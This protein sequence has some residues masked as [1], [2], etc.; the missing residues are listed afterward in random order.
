MAQAMQ[1][2]YFALLMVSISFVLFLLVRFQKHISIY[3]TLMTLAVV[4]VNLG[5]L[6]I[7]GAKTEEG[8]L[9]GNQ[10]YCL[11]Y[12]FLLLF[13]IQSIA[14]L[15]K[16]RI[17][18]AL[19]ALCIVMSLVIFLGASSAGYS[20]LYYRSVEMVI[21][22]GYTFLQ[23][24][25][26]PLHMLSPIY[27]VITLGSG[28]VIVVNALRKKKHVSHVV[29]VGSMCL[30][31]LAA[32]TFVG[33]RAVGL[34]VELL[35]LAYTICAAGILLM[36]DRVA[37]Y[38]VEGISR[39]S[40]EE[41]R[42]YGFVICDDKLRLSGADEQAKLWFPELN[43]LK[44]DY[45]IQEFSTDFLH[46]LRKWVFDADP[47]DVV[48]FERGGRVL[49]ATHSSPKVN[50]RTLHCIRLRDDTAQQQYL[51]LVERYNEKLAEQ[52][53]EKTARLVE[54]QN[55]IIVSMASIVEN[56]DN[57]T[58]G[59]IR[60]TSDVV[61]VFVEHLLDSSAAPGLTRGTAERIITAA[62]LHDF[63]KIA[64]PDSILNKP[65]KFVPEEYEVMKQHAQKGA[66]IVAQIL[67]N[68]DDLQFKDI[69]VNVAHYHH[70]KWDGSGY[71]CGL[72][73]EEIPLEARIMA[74]ADVFDALVSKRVYKEM[75]SFDKAFRI[76]EESSGSHFDPQL[77][78]AFLECREQI[79][80]LYS[81]NLD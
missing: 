53:E 2:L 69:A 76:I 77:C 46:Q 66:G 55:D 21:R 79:E 58:G 19:R 7:A 39:D 72:A 56:R 33:E 71:P 57:N 44:I 13:T 37:T 25:Y 40:L 35:P 70:E 48:F 5:Y 62:P 45:R 42:E 63:G 36:L 50:R 54:V 28:L 3:Y 9:L 68:S 29:S 41:S 8:A 22:D 15:C 11:A 73:G 60:R 18:V 75:Y 43:K 74:L 24:E 10:V 26:G 67:Q 31:L 81:G 16:T 12:P 65:G 51:K 32:L 49:E 59:H 78:G 80:A 4:I 20:D 17:P 27:I 23:R 52:V 47:Q 34:Q 1:P 38:D 14:D 30:L 6:Q 64:I 61:R